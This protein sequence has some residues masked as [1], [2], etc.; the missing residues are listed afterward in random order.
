[1]PRIDYKSRSEDRL[2]RKS[3]TEADYCSRNEETEVEPRKG[4]KVEDQRRESK[5]RTKAESTTSTIEDKNQLQEHNEKTT[6]TEYQG[7]PTF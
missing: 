6:D 4:V 2:P 3:T 5:S 1:M 7:E